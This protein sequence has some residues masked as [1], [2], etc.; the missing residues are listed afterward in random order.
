MTIL[1]S[2]LQFQE[3]NKI[4]FYKLFFRVFQFLFHSIP[5][6]PIPIPRVVT[7]I[8]YIPTPIPR[9]PTLIPRIPRI[10]IPIPRI[11]TLIPRVPTLIACVPII[12][13]SPFPDSPFRLLQIASKKVFS[14][15][16]QSISIIKRVVL[17]NN[18]KARK[19]KT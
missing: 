18:N 16:L 2:F 11:P 17:I 5:R 7:L 9:I 1:I 10:P 12:P 3:K 8:P 14:F 19:E 13:L 4:R 6:I 15:V